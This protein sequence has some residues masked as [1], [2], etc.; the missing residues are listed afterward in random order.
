MTFLPTRGVELMMAILT[1]ADNFVSADF[2]R[3]LAMNL[4]NFNVDSVNYSMKY[5]SRWGVSYGQ[6]R[7]SG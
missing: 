4:S 7:C 6:K 1:P 5:E 2:L 3:V